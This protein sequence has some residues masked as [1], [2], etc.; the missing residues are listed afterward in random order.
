MEEF[1]CVHFQLD[2]I[3]AALEPVNVLGDI[4]P[5]NVQALLA[6]GAAKQVTLKGYSMV[7]KIVIVLIPT[8]GVEGDVL[9]RY[10]PAKAL[11]SPNGTYAHPSR[12]HLGLKGLPES[13]V[14]GDLPP[15]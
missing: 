1:V 2:L 5:P 8:P 4:E 10:D 3:K 6:Y 7:L 13:C 9:T 14:Q 12:T 11:P 15:A